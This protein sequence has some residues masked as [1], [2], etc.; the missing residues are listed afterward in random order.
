MNRKLT[1]YI[2]LLAVLIGI[3]IFID[4]SRPKPVNWTPTYNTKDKIPLGLYVLDQ[5]APALFKGQP[6]KKFG[7]TP[8]EYFDA[9]Y[10]YKTKKYKAKGTFLAI[11]EENNIDKESAKELLYFAER[12]NTVFLSMKDFPGILLDTLQVKISGNYFMKDSIRMSLG[13]EQAK[14]YWFNEGI[15]FTCFDSIE[16]SGATALGYQDASDK[17]QPNFIRVPFGEGQFLLHT[18]PAAFSNFHL[19]KNDHYQYAE[20]V[21]SYFPQGNIYWHSGQRDENISSS[22]FRY[23]NS[24]PGLKW[25]FRIGLIAIVIF[26]FFNAKRKQ[27]IIPEITPLKNTTVDFTKT[28]GNLYY[29]EGNH[30]TIIEKK[31]IYFLEH[32]RNEY[33][34]DTYTLDEKFI[35]KLHLK[36]GKSFEDIQKTVGLIKKH[37]H[38]FQS[39]E[40]DV[41]EIN[42]AI[43]KLRL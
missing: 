24:Q 21:L 6:I 25:A 31:I 32:I 13:R 22:P 37:R 29:Q 12:G 27:R 26:I 43:E 11:S 40:A 20:S 42:K 19:L 8:Y 3:I 39:T 28:I 2:V 38:Q 15:G 23:I 30:H 4:A 36:S 41:I 7:I 33:M 10:D 18:Q 1:I 34:I 5:E 17:D 9:L 16:K 14:K 35:E